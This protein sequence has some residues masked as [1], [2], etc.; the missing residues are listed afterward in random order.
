MSGRPRLGIVTTEL[1]RPSEVWILRQAR[2][3]RRFEPVL[4]GWR[5]DGEAL[6]GGAAAEFETHLFG[7]D[8]RPPATTWRRALGRLGRPEAL[9][10]GSRARA[11]LRETLLGAGL[12]GVLC[13]FAWNYI[14]LMEAVGDALPVVLHVH[15]RDA[16]AYLAWPGNRGAL[17]RHLNRAAHLVAVGRHQLEALAP[18]GLPAGRSVIPCG[19]PLAG[20]VEPPVPERCPG[21]PLRI[22]NVGRLSP[23]KGV[24]ETLAAAERLAREGQEIA[25]TY[26]GDGALRAEIAARSAAGP[27]AGRVR[28]AGWLAPEAVAEALG[29]AHVFTLHSRPAGGWVEGFGVAITEAG[30]RGLPIVASRLGGIP[31]Q[32]FEGENGFLFAPDDVAGQAAALARL[33]ADEALRR[34]MGARARAVARR[35]DTALMVAELEAVLA[36]AIPRR[37]G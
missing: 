28:L 3:L 30:A 27:L 26:I 37:P 32:V 24:L 15:G 12:D 16:S 9:R 4:F 21:A 23:E 29:E 7:G 13:H 2:G 17:R 20:L 10:P 33:A 36:A 18:L 11:A 35:F 6:G 14:P 31:D 8:P 1:D 34:R 19:T 25:L 5:R 22:V